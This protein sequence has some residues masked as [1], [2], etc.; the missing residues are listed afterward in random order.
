MQPAHKRAKKHK[1]VNCNKS[2]INQTQPR[3]PNQGG[4]GIQPFFFERAVNPPPQ[5]PQPFNF[6]DGQQQVWRNPYFPPPANFKMGIQ[7]QLRNGSVKA[8]LRKGTKAKYKQRTN[9]KPYILQVSIIFILL[10]ALWSLPR[11]PRLVVRTA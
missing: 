2:T 5:P 8:C 7:S 3:I 4:H 11:W 10:F 9:E 6:Q 1:S